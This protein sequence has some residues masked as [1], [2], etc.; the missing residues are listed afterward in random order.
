MN[1]LHRLEEMIRTEAERFLDSAR[2]TPVELM[3]RRD[4]KQLALLGEV[5][6]SSGLQG[7]AGNYTMAFPLWSNEAEYCVEHLFVW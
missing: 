5:S 6:Q 3:K 1:R 2:V 7:K 4:D